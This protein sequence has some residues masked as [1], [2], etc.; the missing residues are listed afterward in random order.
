[1]ITL[2]ETNKH[3]CRTQLELTHISKAQPR[4]VYLLIAHLDLSEKEP[5]FTTIMVSYDPKHEKEAISQFRRYIYWEYGDII[6]PEVL[7][8]T[9][10]GGLTPH[11]S[12]K[13][14]EQ[15]TPFADIYW[16]T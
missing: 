1:M 3:G 4:S 2:T 10:T 11:S 7:T 8:Y 9:L 15:P 6:V 12:K 16:K 13:F 5:N 14:S